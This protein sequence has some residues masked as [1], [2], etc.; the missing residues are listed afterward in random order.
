LPL[1]VTL[2]FPSA[3][4]DEDRGTPTVVDGPPPRAIET[5]VSVRMKHVD[6]GNVKSPVDRNARPSSLSKVTSR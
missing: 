6:S 3:G 1:V 2:P 4:E 5:P